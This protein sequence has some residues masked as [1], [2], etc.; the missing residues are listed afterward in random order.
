MSK[1]MAGIELCEEENSNLRK[2]LLW[3]AQFLTVEQ[4]RELRNKLMEPIEYGGVVENQAEDNHQDIIEI[5][6]LCVKA[7]KYLRVA[8]KVIPADANLPNHYWHAM[9]EMLANNLMQF[10]PPS[11]TASLAEIRNASEIEP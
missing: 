9:A 8:I 4:R 1:P 10:D 5:K 3:A 11:P 2:H 7:A 6:R